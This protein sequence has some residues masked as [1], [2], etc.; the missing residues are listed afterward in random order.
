METETKYHQKENLVIKMIA[1]FLIFNL[2]SCATKTLIEQKKDAVYTIINKELKV[3]S[4]NLKKGEVFLEKKLKND[5]PMCLDSFD[6]KFPE[7][8]YEYHV[9]ITFYSLSKEEFQYIFNEEQ[10]NY[11]KEQFKGIA[12]IDSSKIENKNLTITDTEKLKYKGD[13]N[14]IK[15]LITLTYPVFTKNNK[16]ALIKYSLG[17]TIGDGNSS[18]AIY[19]RENNKW[20]LFRRIGLGIG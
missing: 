20:I 13:T 4:P 12:L 7:E 8:D 15:I 10:I 11:Y 6:F 18:I 3:I 16:Y 2:S 9:L 5:L 14:D 17:N 19:K 1:F